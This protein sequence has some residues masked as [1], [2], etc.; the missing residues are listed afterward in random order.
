MAGDSER[1]RENNM[2]SQEFK[3]RRKK[4]FATQTEAAKALGVS[5]A[6]VCTWE[7]GKAVIPKYVGIILDAL[8]KRPRRKTAG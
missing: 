7:N 4:L 8:E 3:A 2:N 6:S 1:R 5:P